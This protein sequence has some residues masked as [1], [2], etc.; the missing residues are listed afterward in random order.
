MLAAPFLLRELRMPSTAWKHTGI[1]L[2]LFPSL[3][4]VLRCSFPVPCWHRWDEVT[5]KDTLQPTTEAQQSRL[6]QPP[7]AAGGHR[8]PAA[9]EVAPNRCRRRGAHHRVLRV[10]AEDGP[11][12]GHYHGGRLDDG[13]GVPAAPV[14][15][16][17]ATGGQWPGAA[18]GGQAQVIAGHRGVRTDTWK[19]EQGVSTRQ[20]P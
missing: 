17:V 13:G 20:R 1:S 3:L 4:P 8:H 12:Q 6:P 7:G 16:L 18:G 11:G 14:A 15:G 19:A 5:G 9:P 2:V 10:G